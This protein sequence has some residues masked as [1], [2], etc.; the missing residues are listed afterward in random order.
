[1]AA[2]KSL[3]PAVSTMPANLGLL[4]SSIHLCELGQV[5]GACLDAEHA[6]TVGGRNHDDVARC[7]HANRIAEKARLGEMLKR[8]LTRL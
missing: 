8:V 2:S 7:Q 3:A 6:R 5:A 1:M 4:P